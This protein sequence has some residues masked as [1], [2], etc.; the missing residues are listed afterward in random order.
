MRKIAER[1]V[2]LRE[3]VGVGRREEHL[4]DRSPIAWPSQSLASIQQL[5]KDTKS[6]SRASVLLPVSSLSVITSIP[7]IQ[8]IHLKQTRQEPNS[9][10]HILKSPDLALRRRRQRRGLL[11]LLLLPPRNGLRKAPQLRKPNS[12]ALALA[13][14]RRVRRRRATQHPLRWTNRARRSARAQ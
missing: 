14:Q 2:R 5:P 4:A 11:L 3:N 10:T 12:S 7:P 8:A 13:Y 9:R 6:A 1:V